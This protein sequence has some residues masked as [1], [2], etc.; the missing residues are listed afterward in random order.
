MRWHNEPAA[1]RADGAR[2]T[3]TADPR[4]DFWRET[5]YGFVRGNGHLY[6]EDVEG[7][8]DA[9][10]RVAGEYRQQYDQAGLM[11]YADHDLWLKCGI[12]FVDG[13]QQLSAVVTR[14]VSDWS[15]V[16]LSPA[17]AELWLRVERRGPDLQLHWSLDGDAF[18][19]F[20]MARLTD[21]P[22]RVGMMCAAPDGDGFPVIFTGFSV[23]PVPDPERL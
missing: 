8:F 12:E 22:V 21:G 3:V 6:A 18:A 7:D 10:V 19:M 9:S 16:P 15:V 1:W 4:T 23:R 2:L 17:P 11:V 13:G 20:R 5:H 14:A